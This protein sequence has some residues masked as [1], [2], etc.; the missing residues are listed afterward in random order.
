MESMN[1]YLISHDFY[2]S[3]GG[4]AAHVYNLAKS[5]ADGGD[6]VTVLSIRYRRN[7]LPLKEKLGNLTIFRFLVP[8]IGKIRGL[9]F[10]LQA[11]PFLFFKS[12]FEKIDVI[13]WHNLFPDTIVSLFGFS[14][15]TVFTNHSS[16]FL[17]LYDNW[18][19]VVYYRCIF[20][21]NRYIIAPSNELAEKSIKYFKKKKT[22]VF[23]I[24]NGVDVNKFQPLSAENHA[25]LKNEILRQLQLPMQSVVVFCPR[26]MEPKNGV[27]YLIRAIPDILKHYQETFFLFA[28]N[29][30]VP[31]YAEMVRRTVTDLNVGKNVIFLGSVANDTILKYYQIS[32]MVVLP[33][34]MEATSIAG[35]EAMACGVPLV[36]TRV[37]GIPEIIDDEKTGLLVSPKNEGELSNAIVRLI[38]NKSLRDEL[39]RS[40]RSR[41]VSE[42][43]WLSIASKTRKV[44]LMQHS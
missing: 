31:D 5:L 16:H 11:G 2:P 9:C 25:H 29:D 14:A 17:E 38:K 23:S 33:S 22:D 21:R 37:G 12:F 19:E 44:Y 18:S 43:S 24:S 10:I 6:K 42:F 30:T 39:G 36:G 7:N 20:F 8:D 32:D 27:D 40:A 4:I 15:N 26:R 34:L 3:I 35:L 13:H 28:G 1:A 41:A